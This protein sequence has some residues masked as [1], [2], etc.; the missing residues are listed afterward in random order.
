MYIGGA[1][2]AR[3]YLNQPELTLERFLEDPFT[4]EPGARMY[5]TGDL[6]R[7]MPDGNLEFLGRNDNQVKIRGFRIESG[8]IEARLTEHPAVR[9]AYVLALGEESNK[10][11]IAYVVADE[12]NEL[13][14]TLRTFLSRL[15]PEYMV[16]AAFVRLEA[17]PLTPNGKLN[18]RALPAPDG[19][20]FARRAYEAPIGP[21]ETALAEIWSELLGVEGISRH[22]S[23]F[24]LGGHSLLAVR[25]LERLRRIGL[26]LAIR[27]LFQ[28]P[29]LSV[30]AQNLGQHREVSVPPN[31]ITTDIRAL[32][33]DLLPLIEL[34]QSE[35]DHI[36][37]QVPGGLSNLQDIYALSP[38]QDGILFHHLLATEGDPYLLVSQMIF[39]DRATLD[40]YLEAVQQV[41]NRHD[42]LRT[43]FV[44][45]GLSNPAQVVWRKAPL[46]ITELSLDPAEGPIRK[47][48]MQRFNPRRHR[49]DLT[50]APLIRFAFAQDVDGRWILLQLLHHLI[51]DH[52]TLEVMDTEVRA[53]LS[54]EGEHLPA[55]QP[56][57]N[58]VAQAR[59]GVSQAE[60]ERFFSNMLAEIDTP[61]LPFGLSEVY[62]DGSEVT[63][64]RRK[65]S[66]A[67]NERL[68][69]QARRLGVS[70]ASLC[71]LAWAQVLSR[72][73]GG[74][75]KVVFGTVLFGRMQAGDGADQ[76]MGLF[77]NTLPLRIDLD[78]TGVEESVRITHNRLADLLVHEHASLATAQRCSGLPA[79]TPLFSA[80]LNYRH[81]A[82]P[83]GKA[84][85]LSGIE[86][87]GGQERTNYPLTL[88][89]EDYG[90]ALGL[91]VELMQP[92][93]PN[94]VCGYMEEAL[95]SLVEALEH[96]PL[97][98]VRELNI[99]PSEERQ[100]L[101]HTWNET[102]ADYPADQC[103]H[104]LF[105]EQV[106][107]TPEAIA[108][109]YE[110]QTLTYA[111]LNARA[112]KLAHELIKL[113][114]EPDARV[115]ICVE[116]SPAMVVGLLA[117]LKAGGVYVPLD[118]AYPG[119]RLA[120]ILADASPQIVLA[121][122]TGRVTL[123]GA[124]FSHIVLDPNIL[125][126]QPDNNSTVPTLTSRHLAYV[127]YTSGSTGTPKGV[128]V[129]HHSLVNT[130]YAM[131]QTY[132]LTLQDKVLQKSL[133]GFD[134]S[135]W[136]C[137]WPL[138]SGASLVVTPP[139]IQKAPQALIDLVLGSHYHYGLMYPLCYLPFFGI[140][141][142]KQP[143]LAIY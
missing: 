88:S 64:A 117:I 143:E 130:I 55:P 63:Q 134:V 94:R 60:H 99:L 125:S 135:V 103:I 83:T 91:T 31:R 13:P 127:I 46:S 75:E 84:N 51:G 79:G 110:K 58:L 23:F 139:N 118:P 26:S 69:A 9:E 140:R 10:R 76:A 62:H 86:F 21:I 98:A 47:Q 93:D 29:T 36:V 2:V 109:V 111:E 73:S 72:V 33:P 131:C 81:N 87:L 67:L 40:R 80:L 16:P 97:K 42:I 19:D 78:H 20:A 133:F 102:Q 41:V 15:L 59:L 7:Y 108:L 11:L 37:A 56:F 34:T 115:A 120:H 6:A 5:R 57:R 61:T 132:P 14:A 35:I 74:Q 96:T 32:T 52:S 12:D 100:L 38:L 138:L 24:E 126:S 4:K 116:R 105:E 49:I 53:F 28:S 50:Q 48:L 123:G 70:L 113:G 136:E 124:L 141:A 129:E 22:D 30:L 54:G 112:N 18:R 90:Q 66:Q 65:L 45:Q 89:V 68:R 77:I 25:L 92:L 8:E 142:I 119:E 39:S 137:F 71:H 27:D 101:L 17:F 44:W 114:V 82:M 121:D 128:M 107:R 106:E 1:G 95:T 3:G 104:Q 122:E 43:A 85:T